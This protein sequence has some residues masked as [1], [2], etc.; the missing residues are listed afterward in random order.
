MVNINNWI[1]LI[2][3]KVIRVLLVGPDEYS[4]ET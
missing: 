4:V 3:F 2:E 1:A